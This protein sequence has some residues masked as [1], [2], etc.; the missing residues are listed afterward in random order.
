MSMAIEPFHRTC[1]LESDTENVIMG[2]RIRYLTRHEWSFL[3]PRA[4]TSTSTWVIVPRGQISATVFSD[5]VTLPTLAGRKSPD[6]LPH[7]PGERRASRP[8]SK[9]AG[10]LTESPGKLRLTLGA[11]G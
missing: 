5:A 7:H 2:V 1:L 6:W 8:N 4:S 10:A 3:C 9:Q 11:A